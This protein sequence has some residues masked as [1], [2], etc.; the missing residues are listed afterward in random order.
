[1]G[2]T[3]AGYRLAVLGGDERQIFLTQSLLE[4]GAKVK[5]LGFPKRKELIG[6]HFCDN[7][8]EAI[9]DVEA[10]ILPMP[11]TDLEGNI[12]TLGNDK[13]KITEKYLKKF[14][15]MYRYT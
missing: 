2:A 15:L 13:I 12:I 6:C 7:I 5:V 4:K 1:M 3:L 9:S 8:L 11:G 10:I 14:P